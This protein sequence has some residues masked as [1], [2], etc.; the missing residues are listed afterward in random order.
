MPN[1]D[2]KLY[3]PTDAIY[4]D[5]LRLRNATLSE[6]WRGLWTSESRRRSRQ[7]R[8]VARYDR[9]VSGLPPALLDPPHSDI[10]LAVEGV[11]TTSAC[12]SSLG[13]VSLACERYDECGC[14]TRRHPAHEGRT[15]GAWDELEVHLRASAVLE[16]L[17]S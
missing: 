3:Q 9:W 5:A 17:K 2:A 7:E 16:S 1:V 4:P 8:L 11:C 6:L 12:C 14:K 10:T 15:F 13:L